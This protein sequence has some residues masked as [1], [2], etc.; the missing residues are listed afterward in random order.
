MLCFV[1]KMNHQNEVFLKSVKKRLQK[2]F[3]Q[4]DVTV[5]SPNMHENW[6]NYAYISW[7]LKKHFFGMV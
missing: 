5:F 1:E 3:Y 6:W 2:V 7:F 4:P